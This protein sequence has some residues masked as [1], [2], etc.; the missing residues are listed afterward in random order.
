MDT[1]AIMALALE[2]ARQ[3][4]VPPDSGI[5]VPA[6]NVRR[7]L[8]GIDADS[9]DLLIAKQLGYDL[10]IN[11]HPTGGGSQ[12]NFPQVLAKHGIILERAG[13]PK[14]VA[15]RAVEALLDEHE[16]A[17]HARNYDH[18]P[19]EARLLGMPLMAIHNPCDEIGRRV[20]DETLRAGLPREATV[21]DGIAVLNRLPEF[22]KA[23]TK[24]VVRMGDERHALG[25]WVVIHG[26]GTNGGYPVAKAAFD[27]G[28]DTVFYIH[29]DA[30]HL[31]R[32]RE[33]YGRGGPKNLVVTGHIASDSIGINVLIREL[34]KRGVTVD[35]F[36][37]VLDV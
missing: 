34:R 16:S 20:M 3:G 35:A 7:A 11:H 14:E 33:E 8:F 21:R 30:G 17:A 2:L 29:I 31:R 9:G 6:A 27:H 12:V 24:I 23:L 28:I 5:D 22:Q 4:E 26:A 32:L 10:L 15:R 36:G 13:V 25:K 37:G 18:L 1:T 19:S